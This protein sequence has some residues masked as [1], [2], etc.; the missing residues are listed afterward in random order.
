MALQSVCRNRVGRNLLTR[1]L[2]LLPRVS[3]GT[4]I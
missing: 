4:E 3:M 2:L 1:E